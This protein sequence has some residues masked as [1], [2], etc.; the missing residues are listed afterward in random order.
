M[1]QQGE[2]CH[3]HE[4]EQQQMPVADLVE[5]LEELTVVVLEQDK[6]QRIDGEYHHHADEHLTAFTQMLHTV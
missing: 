2:A 5:G 3:H 6:Y 1:E 4:R